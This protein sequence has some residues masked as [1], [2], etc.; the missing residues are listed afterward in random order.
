MKIYPYVHFDGQCREAFEF[1]A[2]TLGGRITIS[3]TYGEAPTEM[4]CPE[5]MKHRIMH[6]C[7]VAGDGVL[8]G[9]DDAGPGYEGVKGAAL[10]F[11]AAAPAEAERVFTALGKGG[12]VRMGLT[13]T[14]WAHRFGMLTDRFGTPWMVSCD[15]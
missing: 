15:K 14:F 8:M 2:A 12:T 10:S 7:V 1:Y 3:M 13:E 11:H 5:E 6:T 9:P 4:H